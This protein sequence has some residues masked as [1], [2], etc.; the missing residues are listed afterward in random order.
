MD[1][2]NDSVLLTTRCLVFCESFISTTWPVAAQAVV[3]FFKKMNW[4]TSSW[5][6]SSG[7]NRAAQKEVANVA[8]HSVEAI[9][10]NWLP[11]VT[12]RASG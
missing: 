9:E 5:R 10:H 2:Q 12:A 8:Q 4:A 1:F 7:P 3:W 11:I 6:S